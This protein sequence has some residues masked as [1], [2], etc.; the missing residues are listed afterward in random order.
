MHEGQAPVASAHLRGIFK[1]PIITAGGF[2]RDGAEATLAKGDADLVAFGRF[3]TSNPDLPERLRNGWPL[4][5]YVREA[6]W[7]GDERHY[8]DFEPYSETAATA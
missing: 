4:T 3:F 7:S 8:I 2:D 5:P 1:G 6:F